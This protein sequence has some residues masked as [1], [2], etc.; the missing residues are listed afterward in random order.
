[1]MK[2]MM[3]AAAIAALVG[4]VPAAKQDA[5]TLQKADAPPNGVWLDSLD[6]S[7]API[8][9]GRGQRGSTTPLPPL[10]FKLGGVTYLHA[11]PLVSDGDLAVDL[12]GAATRL[13]SMVGIDDGNPAQPPAAGAPPP[14]P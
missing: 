5:T 12:G 9:R 7:S 14:P 1:A 2:L 4:M 6:L 13:V 3:C 8:R 11:L 10:V